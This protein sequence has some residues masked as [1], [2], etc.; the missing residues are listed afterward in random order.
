[1]PPFW[2]YIISYI[3]PMR[4][5]NFKII[6]ATGCNYPLLHMHI[7]LPKIPRKR[8]FCEWCPYAIKNQLIKVLNPLQ[9]RISI[10]VTY[11]NSWHVQANVW[12]TAYLCNLLFI[13]LIAFRSGD[14]KYEYNSFRLPFL[15]MYSAIPGDIGNRNS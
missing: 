4:V 11:C 10:L 3:L 5:A 1:M 13:A 6:F 9:H 12:F 7:H 2:A 15:P 14:T 8:H